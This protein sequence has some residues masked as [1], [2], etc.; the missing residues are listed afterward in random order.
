MTVE[1]LNEKIEAE[2]ARWAEAEEGM[3]QQFNQAFGAHQGR[4]SVWQEQIEELEN[5]A[6]DE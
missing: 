4:L 6:E 5:P 2:K 3:K 1:E